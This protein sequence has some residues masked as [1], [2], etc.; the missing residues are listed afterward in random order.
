MRHAEALLLVDDEKPQVLEVQALLQQR[1]CA[2][3][4]VD[5]S[6]GGILQNL[7]LLRRRFEAREHFD[8]HGERAEAVQ[9]RRIVLLGEHG[10]RH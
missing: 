2:D 5:L 7:L 6:R 10:G 1:V 9:R 3:Q 4:K 8:A